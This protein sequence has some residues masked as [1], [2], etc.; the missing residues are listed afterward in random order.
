M[1]KRK[2]LSAIRRPKDHAPH[3]MDEVATADAAGDVAK[4]RETHY[5]GA[6]RPRTEVPS[7]RPRTSALPRCEAKSMLGMLPV[8]TAH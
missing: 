8:P 1:A 2:S 7:S 3:P 4:A 6:A 5:R